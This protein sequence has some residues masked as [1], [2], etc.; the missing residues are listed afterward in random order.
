MSDDATIRCGSWISPLPFS[1]A[2]LEHAVNTAQKTGED[3]IIERRASQALLI[4]SFRKRRFRIIDV[5]FDDR[6]KVIWRARHAARPNFA[7]PV[8]RGWRALLSFPPELVWS[9]EEAL[10]FAEAYSRGDMPSFPH[11]WIAE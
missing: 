6:D 5:G 3:A 7:G 8:P 11:Q 10:K 1:T 4:R 9:D 2:A